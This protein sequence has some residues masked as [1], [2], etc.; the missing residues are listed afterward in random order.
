M[1]PSHVCSIKYGLTGLE[2]VIYIDMADANCLLHLNSLITNIPYW[3]HGFPIILQFCR[4]SR[5][6]RFPFQGSEKYMHAKLVKYHGNS[7]T[8]QTIS[9]SAIWI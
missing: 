1:L 3:M 9:L 7:Q 2:E 6:F 5:R 4:F 8:I